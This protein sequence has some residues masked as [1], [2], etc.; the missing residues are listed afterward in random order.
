MKDKRCSIIIPA[1]NEQEN[2]EFT[3]NRIL[4]AMR[5]PFECI[6]VVDDDYDLSK[7]K[8]VQLNY[9]PNIVRCIVNRG[10]SGFA[11]AIRTGIQES[12]ASVIVIT[13]ADGSDDPEDISQLVKLIERGVT[14]ACASRYIAGGQQIGAPKIKS[15]LSRVAGKSFSFITNAQTLDPTNNFKAY[16][17]EFIK[18]YGIQSENGFEVG[19]EL[20][21]KAVR[22]KHLIAEVPTIWIERNLGISNF[23]IL[24]SL[25]VYLKW[26]LYGVGII[27]RNSKIYN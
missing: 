23:K 8:I 12:R 16:S 15:Y 24:K 6:V 25:P 18:K 7:S 9:D 13:M 4:E 20:V 26:Y 11:S 10:Q 21:A 17:K 19:L 5:L 2:I 1:K 27:R 3:L 22:H 14:V